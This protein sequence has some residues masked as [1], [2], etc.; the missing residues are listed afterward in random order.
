MYSS[1]IPQKQRKAKRAEN[2]SPKM[3]LPVDDCVWRDK[4]KMPDNSFPQD[5]SLYWRPVVGRE[6]REKN[7]AAT[8]PLQLKISLFPPDIKQKRTRTKQ[9]ENLESQET[10]N[11]VNSWNSW[12]DFAFSLAKIVAAGLD[13]L[14]SMSCCFDQAL[15]PD[16][17]DRMEQ[18]LFCFF[19]LVVQLLSAL[20]YL[21]SPS[22]SKREQALV[23]ECPQL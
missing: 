3:A 17:G 5:G 20:C 14:D 4:G 2:L 12:R 1:W 19:C 18:G 8:K 10:L 23:P 22:K 9:K 15:L 16:W 6:Q 11:W 21:S 7:N 13:N